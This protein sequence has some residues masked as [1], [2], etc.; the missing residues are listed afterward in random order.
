MRLAIAVVLAAGCNQMLDLKRT[1][2]LPAP[3]APPPLC[4]EGTEPQQQSIPAS[5]DATIIADGN[6]QNHGDTAEVFVKDSG[7]AQYGLWKFT[8]NAALDGAVDA[9]LVLPYIVRELDCGTS[10]GTV[11]VSCDGDDIGGDLT[12]YPLTS[13]WDERGNNWDCR[14]GAPHCAVTDQWNAPGAGGSDRGTPLMTV[15][16]VAASDTEVPLQLALPAMRQWVQGETLS[17]VV[18]ASRGARAWIP[19]ITTDPVHL[20]CRPPSVAL[21]V[22]TY[23]S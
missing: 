3:D 4:P 11:C 12:I 16:H 5:A 23:C 6:P 15:E 9:R 21:L 18:V 8:V 13:D 19:A 22:V 10:G 17:I 14:H 20:A 2:E 7:P 1:H